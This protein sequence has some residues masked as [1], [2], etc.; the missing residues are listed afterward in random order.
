MFLALVAELTLAALN[1]LLEVLDL[2]SVLLQIVD[3]KS[4]SEH[5]EV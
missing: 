1:G 3:L 4:A 5:D 2:E